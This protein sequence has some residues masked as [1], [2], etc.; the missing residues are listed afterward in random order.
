MVLAF[1]LPALA[2]QTVTLTFTGRDQNGGYVRLDHVT[3]ENL[4]RDWA[5]TVW[6]PDTVY[7]LTVGTGISGYSV[8]NALQVM[9]TPL[10]ER[11]G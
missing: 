4:T 9:P 2:Q 6:F 1:L 11:R 3:I 8:G 5:D 7:T 10:T